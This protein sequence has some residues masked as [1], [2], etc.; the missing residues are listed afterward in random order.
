MKAKE[1]YR[2]DTWLET[3]HLTKGSLRQDAGLPSVALGAPPTDAV[4]PHQTDPVENMFEQNLEIK[5]YISSGP[6]SLSSHS[7]DEANP[8]KVVD[9]THLP[10]HTPTIKRKEYHSSIRLPT[11]SKSHRFF[12]T[13][14]TAP[15]KCHQCTSLMVGLIRQGCA[16]D[17]CGFSCHTT[18][19][20]KAPRACPV[21]SQQKKGALCLDAQAGMGTA[22]E[23]RV[24]IP[25]KAGA[26]K[27][28]QRA[29]A[30][31]CD[32][33]LFLYNM[34]EE[35]DSKPNVVVSQVIDMRS[36]H[37]SSQHLAT[38]TRYPS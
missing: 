13:S 32:F 36:R 24:W 9:S 14:F 10:V 8:V 30:V 11:K 35:K 5:F 20:E 12:L 33:K 37:R 3:D 15:T 38:G 17:A 25:K 2:S 31:V 18:C 26:R 29:L 21:P 6:A 4:A 1:Q 27:G 19:V 34:D 7:G 28:W 22:Y 16:C 23:G